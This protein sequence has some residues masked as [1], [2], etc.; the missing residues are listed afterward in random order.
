MT[1]ATRGIGVGN[2]LRE[3]DGVGVHA[4]EALECM[5]IEEVD[6][7]DGGEAGLALV[8]MFEGASRIVVIDCAKMGLSPGDIRVF[9]SESIKLDEV[10]DL[11]GARVSS[12]VQMGTAL[13]LLPDDLL[14]IGVEPGRT[15]WGMSMSPEVESAIPVVC[16]KV[17]EL[18][19]ER[20]NAVDPN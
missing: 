11:H 18:L 10:P 20:C 16:R 12:A 13:G 6:L 3:D 8:S 19:G 4:I 9:R 14:F 15:G 17:V 1:E 5:E 7:V 2:P